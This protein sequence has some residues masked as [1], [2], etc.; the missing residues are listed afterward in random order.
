MR[1][2]TGRLAPLT[3]EADHGDG[4][5]GL[6]ALRRQVEQRPRVRLPKRLKLLGL[7]LCLAVATASAAQS[8]RATVYG[9]PSTA[10]RLVGLLDGGSI[11]SPTPF[12]KNISTGTTSSAIDIG[13]IAGG[14]YRLRILAQDSGANLL[15]SGKVSSINVPS[16]STVNVSPTLAP[17]TVSVNGA[18]PAST[19]AGGTAAVL[20]DIYDAGG[21]VRPVASSCWAD[22]STDSAN[23]SNRKFG[24]LTNVSGASYQCSVLVATPGNA[25]LLHYRFG[26]YA[27]EF[28]Y[29]GVTPVL[30][31]PLDTPLT[32]SLV[33]ASTV[34]LTVSNIPST[35]TRLVVN[36]DGG[37]LTA[38]SISAANISAGAP[39]AL[40]PLGV[41]VG[42]PYR[43]RVL[44]H[45]GSQ[46]L[47]RTGSATGIA[48][49]SGGSVPA[50]V[51]LADVSTTV[52]SSTPSAAAYG[53]ALAVSMDFI[54]TGLVFRT[55]DAQCWIDYGSAGEALTSRH[56]GA[57]TNTGG[58]QFKCSVPMTA[59]TTGTD[60]YYRMSAYAFD[61]QYERIT[62]IFT[63]PAGTPQSIGLASGGTIRLEIGNCASVTRF[64]VSID[65][66]NL[67]R[68]LLIPVA[69]TAGT[70]YT[71][72][73]LSVPAG[74]PYR[75]RLAAHDAA[76]RVLCADKLAGITVGEGSSST[77]S[78]GL[79]ALNVALNPST[80]FAA[81]PGSNV[82]L[83]FD[84]S[85][86]GEV[87]PVGA[88]SCAAS[89][90][91]NATSL[92][93]R[94]FGTLG[95]TGEDV[96][97][98]KYYRCT[99]NLTLPNFTSD[100]YYE[101]ETPLTEF[102]VDG[103]MPWVVGP[104]TGPQRL[105]TSS[106]VTVSTIPAGLNIRVDEVPYTSP[107][108]FTW[109]PGSTHVVS[110]ETQSTADTRYVF[111]SW[112]DGGTAT[113]TVT[114]PDAPSLY[115]S[116][117]F[118]VK[119]KFTLIADPP[120][121][122]SVSTSAPLDE[123]F[124]AGWIGITATSN[125]GY[126]FQSWTGDTNSSRN[127]E[128]TLV[129]RPRTVTAHFSGP[130]GVTLTTNP[131]G[132]S[133]TVD[134]AAYTSPQTFAW[135]PGSTHSIAAATQSTANTRY[136]FQ[137]WSDAGAAAHTVTTPA[138]ALALTANFNV[139]Y[140]FTLIVDPPE[141]GSVSTSAPLD[142][143]SVAGWIGI[144]AT[145]N[146]GY[147]FQSWTGDTNSSR[148][149]EAT[150]VDRPRTVTA[151]FS[152][153]PGVTLT[154]NPP[155]LSITVDGA[156]LHFAPDLRLGSRLHPLHCRGHPEHCQ[157]PLPVPELERCR[158][159][160]AHCHHACHGPRAYR[161]LQRQVQ[162]H[163]DRRSARGGFRLHQ[164]AVG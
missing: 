105:A 164:R 72:T 34:N 157:H 163:A 99:V 40:I 68:P 110:T 67:P 155:G 160:R 126:Q 55:G 37:S 75:I 26:T 131:P 51:A 89:F 71:S 78:L 28:A 24:N 118:D 107:Q 17:V 92:P 87:L 121:A 123:G 61:L 74:G 60:L 117:T 161:Q 91:E 153:P 27:Y 115:F 141:A 3:K 42:G 54:D 93:N 100:L 120:E 102:A 129:D 64:V 138:T 127:P 113:H 94:K 53:S 114:T 106:E 63:W 49:G 21:V 14:P 50:D 112:G 12:A 83:V 149:P 1:K 111:R 134:G 47:L 81:A 79:G 45:D 22:W 8:I 144:T 11:I 13:T 6:K 124:V 90:G 69:P 147:Q 20:F 104:A 36:V 25:P 5:C 122:G 44:A 73:T 130:P 135:A 116:A 162:V 76:N 108:T 2:K 137:N 85:E 7:L 133:I 10:T 66:G 70:E 52:A 29:N 150:L 80:A 46:Q 56:Y 103:V 43:A 19:I 31:H 132:L 148:N 84:L 33:A 98:N 86:R 48:S 88:E 9:I 4:L 65:G 35:A 101:L 159:R 151:H 143:G 95:L 97:G 96:F 128:A 62:P 38:A 23:L 154:T 39:S 140:K 145:S 77:Y 18:T 156:R 57:I 41:P 119:Y 158:R 58:S 15:S 146:P 142:E 59:P 16:N 32:M 82:N 109:V 139:K 136:L 30:L 152:G 125:P